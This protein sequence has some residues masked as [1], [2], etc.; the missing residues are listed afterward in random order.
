MNSPGA[1]MCCLCCP[2]CV[3]LRVSRTSVGV[4]ELD[5]D[6][7][8]ELQPELELELE[9]EPPEA[10]HVGPLRWWTLS[11]SSV[12]DLVHVFC[13]H[14][15]PRLL[16]G[17]THCMAMHVAA[18]STGVAHPRSYAVHCA[19]SHTSLTLVLS[20]A[21]SPIPYRT[22]RGVLVAGFSA[23]FAHPQ[24]SRRVS[25]SDRDVLVE[26]DLVSA[27][28]CVEPVFRRFVVVLFAAVAPQCV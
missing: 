10:V 20:P 1:L 7:D 23:C 28:S 22:L 17:C 24:S 9:L 12:S 3:G 13:V 18:L 25:S 4:C 15:S 6:L 2:R 27:G 5:Q 11:S 26:P 21:P 8:L 14:L 16:C 19:L